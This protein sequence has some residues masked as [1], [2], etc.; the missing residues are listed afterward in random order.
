LKKT[1]DNAKQAAKDSLQDTNRRTQT[2]RRIDTYR[3]ADGKVHATGETQGFK[4]PSPQAAPPKLPGNLKESARLSQAHD[5]VGG[6]ASHY[7][8]DKG[9]A[10]DVANPNG[11]GLLPLASSVS[12]TVDGGLKQ[13]FYIPSS[14]QADRAA[15]TGGAFFTTT[16]GINF[17]PAPYH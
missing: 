2:E 4:Y 11:A 1:Y 14:N 7:G 13:E 9:S 17:T 5:H 10:N 6:L 16:D 8:G 15:N 12:S 3:G